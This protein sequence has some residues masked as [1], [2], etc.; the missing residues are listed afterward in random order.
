MPVPYFST[1][2]GI[3]KDPLHGSLPKTEPD[4]EI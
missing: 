2:T 1:T 3:A 4:S